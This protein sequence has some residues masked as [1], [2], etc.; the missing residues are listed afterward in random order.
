MDPD[1]TL[2][3]LTGS[4]I[5]IYAPTMPTG[6]AILTCVKL[7]W[8]LFKALSFAQSIAIAWGL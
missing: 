7:R 2:L 5:V 4:S 1:V 8:R 6:F 3:A